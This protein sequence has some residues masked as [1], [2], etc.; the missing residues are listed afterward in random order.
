M[1]NRNEKYHI[2]F[3]ELKKLLDDNYGRF[4]N[5]QQLAPCVK[6][7]IGSNIGDLY[8]QNQISLDNARY[9]WLIKQIKPNNMATIEIPL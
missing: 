4:S 6:E 9:E 7:K 1:K 8:S 2:I 3:E 5:Y